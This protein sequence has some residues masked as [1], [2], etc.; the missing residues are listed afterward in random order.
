VTS[1]KPEE[2]VEVTAHSSS[3]DLPA[4]L[5]RQK[6]GSWCSATLP[7]P[8]LWESFSKQTDISC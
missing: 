2:Q 4:S 1:V 8:F 5:S 7:C 3:T 6:Q